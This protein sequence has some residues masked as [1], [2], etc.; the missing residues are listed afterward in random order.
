MFSVQLEGALSLSSYAL[1]LRVRCSRYAGCEP[2]NLKGHPLAPVC[3][4]C[5][6]TDD[7]SAAGSL[8]VKALYNA[9]IFYRYFMF[10]D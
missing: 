6:G 1:V 8:F 5:P 7:Q 4:V 2:V 9:S 3:G 10:F